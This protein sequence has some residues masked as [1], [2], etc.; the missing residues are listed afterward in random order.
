MKKQVYISEE[1]RGKCKKVA[2]AFVEL[3]EMENILV[4]DAG[5]FFLVSRD[6]LALIENRLNYLKYGGSMVMVITFRLKT[7]KCHAK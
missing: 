1:E 7:R 5:L 2:D 6:C 3:Y 4:V